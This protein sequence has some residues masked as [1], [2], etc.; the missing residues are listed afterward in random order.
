M[1]KSSSEEILERHEKELRKPRVLNLAV[2]TKFVDGEDTGRECIT[3][4]VSEKIPRNLLAP[5][6]I[7]PSEIEGVPT[8]VV[9][10]GAK[11]YE[12][13]DTEVSRRPPRAQRRIAGGVR[14]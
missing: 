4:Y 7:I 8:D 13:G 10:L 9:E 12:L 2:S 14:R 1:D 6:E 3:A 11:D 5:E